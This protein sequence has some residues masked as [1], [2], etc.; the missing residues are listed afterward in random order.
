MAATT[1]P[2]GLSSYQFRVLA[3]ASQQM[4][5]G[6]YGEAAQ[7][8]APLLTKPSPPA[9]L[10]HYGCLALEQAQQPSLEC[11]QRGQ[12]QQP[13]DKTITLALSNQLLQ[14]QRY[15]QSVEL[16]TPWIDEH[17]SA[18]LRYQ[19]AYSLYQIEAYRQVVDALSIVPPI[20]AQ[21]TQAAATANRQT[22]PNN[23][24][25]L[26]AYS[27]LALQEWPQLQQSAQ[28]WLAVQ[29]DNA[30]AWQLLSQSYLQQQQLKQATA[31][32][33]IAQLLQ[34][35]TDSR[36]LTQLYGNIGA[37]NLAS[38]CR[39]TQLTL[40]CLQYGYWAGDY[41]ATLTSSNTLSVDAEQQDALWLLQ[42]Q[43]YAALEQPQQARNLWWQIGKQPLTATTATAL[44]QQRQQRDHRRG[45][46]LLLIGQSHWLQQQ[47]PEAQ[48]AYRELAQ[49]PQ[50]Q[51]RGQ[52]LVDN[53]NYYTGN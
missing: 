50:F 32:L 39:N 2:Q 30:Q 53:L 18:Q 31:T 14:A 15:Q 51:Q 3:A 21:T 41:Q 13:Q 26:I 8:L 16:L 37:Y 10:F 20:A 6:H 24:W 38:D 29:V 19:Y 45:Q 44:Q 22:R 17:A 35:N 52:N 48:V 33:Q 34:P 28:Q 46:A 47:W 49:L 40:N 1:A 36:T 7:Q 23:W 42:G 12:Q 11:W 27:Q 5:R 4:E 9:V 25:P 43:L